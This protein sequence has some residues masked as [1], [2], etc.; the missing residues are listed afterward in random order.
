MKIKI[1]AGQEDVDGI[2]INTGVADVT[3]SEVFLGV[4]IDTP[5]GYFGIAQRDNGIEII[6]E[7]KMVWS[8]SELLEIDDKLKIKWTPEKIKRVKEIMYSP[9]VAEAM[10]VPLWC[11]SPGEPE[12]KNKNIKRKNKK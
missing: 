9:G 8:S 3:L 2:T 12:I 11:I 5:Q 4:R 6:F 1:N 7:G 10:R